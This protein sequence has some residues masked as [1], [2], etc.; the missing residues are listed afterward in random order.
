MV[1]GWDCLAGSE[2]P[3]RRRAAWKAGPAVA[4]SIWRPYYPRLGLQAPQLEAKSRDVVGLYLNPPENT[5]R[6]RGQLPHPQTR[7]PRARG[8]GT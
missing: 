5:V 6:R 4:R 7:R 1:R 3:Q 8:S 2:P